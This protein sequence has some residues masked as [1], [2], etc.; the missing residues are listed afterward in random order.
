MR[1]EYFTVSVTSHVRAVS[2]TVFSAL[3]AA[4]YARRRREIKN[5]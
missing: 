4:Y 2:E 5:Y 1:D 3:R